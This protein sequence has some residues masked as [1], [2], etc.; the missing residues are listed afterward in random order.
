MNN[1]VYEELDEAK[2]E[3]VKLREQY[4]VKVD[5]SERLKRAHDDQLSNNKEANSKLEKLARDLNEKVDEIS[6]AKQMNDELKSKLTEKE[7]F[8][9]DLSSAH[10]KFRFDFNEKFHKCEEDN[11]VLA[12]SLDDANAKNMDQEKQIHGLKQEIE[13][14]KRVL[15]TSEKKVTE[16]ENSAKMSKE[17][18]EDVW[19]RLEEE[20]RKFEDQLKWKK[21]Q[22]GHLEEAHKKLRDEF[23]MR[24]K[25]WEK[26]K[27][28]L[29]DDANAKNMDQEKQIQSLKQEIEEV[30]KV[31][32]NLEKNRSETKKS[33]TISK[34]G[35]E[36]L[37]LRLEEE[38]RKFEDQLKWKKE[39]FGHL[40][41][42]Y[43]KL[44]NE[45]NMK[46]N[47]WEKEKN[48]LVDDISSLQMNLE[49]QIRISQDL[50]RRLEM[51]NDA[52]AHAESKKKLLEVELLESRT[53]FDNI[54]GEYEEAKSSFED[55]ITQRGQ[56]IANLRSSLG[57]KEILYKEMEYQF[58]KMEQEKQDL[59]VS[60]KELQEEQIHEARIISSSSK[61]QN[62]L[63]S[64]ENVHKGCS[65]NLK[66]KESEW[67]SEMEKLTEELDFCREELKSKDMSL[68]ELKM[69]LKDCDSL[70][71]K[72]ELI[73]EETSL[74]LLILKLEFSEARLGLVEE[75]EKKKGVLKRVQSDLEEEREKVIILSKKVQIL[76]EIQFPLQEELERLK[77]MLK[78]SS[79][80]Q[81]Q[82]EEQIRSDLEKVHEALDRANEEL[83]EKYCEA[84]EIEF[85]LQIWK[86][87]A[88]KLEINLEQN[89]RMRREVEASL[90]AQMDVEVNLKQEKESLGYL[91]EEKEKR[92]E[93]LQQQLVDVNEN[94]KVEKIA[95]PEISKSTNY[96]HD[97]ENLHQLVE[98]K[99]QRIYD[100]QQLVTSLEH[101]FE[102]STGSFSSRLSQ[103]QKEMKFF[104]ESWEKIKEAEVLKEIEIQ[105]KNLMIV[106]LENDLCNLQQ[107]DERQD[108]TIFDSETKMQEIQA[109]LVKKDLE[110]IR[111][112]KII[113]K[114]KEDSTKLSK[115]NKNLADTMCLLHE[116]IER[117][118][119][120]DMKLMGSLGKIVE[121]I[122]IDGPREVGWNSDD[123][124][125]SRE[126]MQT[127]SSP[128]KK[129][130]AIHG[131]R[132][133]FRVINN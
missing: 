131:E 132:S 133:P 20:N 10:D 40:E 115:E 63:K 83:Y 79:T 57:T 21:E 70:M 48:V 71:M 11:K 46:E 25:E 22:F 29:L 23:K 110:V 90:L 41:E 37:C 27:N 74:M 124:E 34:E 59:L 88:E 78:E 99:E 102:S 123:D 95:S 109:E 7:A 119:V 94:T 44:R 61:L 15:A 111:L 62:K 121:T 101:E 51:C 49:S 91:L 66:A 100:L 107:T 93:D 108:K 60:I 1:D 97:K 117:L 114:L 36:D 16:T 12:S 58:K 30:K 86:S 42:A 82:S 104:Q 75:L 85:E 24:E 120:E 31:L 89:H 53:G 69:E 65:I 47:E 98:E 9:K 2:A 5:L 87:M 73:N 113:K 81:V 52:L 76:E 128:L 54:C 56:E 14:V 13:G 126:N 122:D 64:L 77:E 129:V 8:I 26:E 68:N 4:R 67:R 6:A 112:E 118:S 116:R 106:E 105:E 39:Q 80:C 72:L 33:A 19:L 130:E 125:D 103:M 18:R 84:N 45:F 127:F 35:R 28:A 32:A 17:R 3:L 96:N 38:N 55:L 50:Q 43:K 92:I